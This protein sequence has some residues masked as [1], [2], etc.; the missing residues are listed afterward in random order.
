M[1]PSLYGYSIDDFKEEARELLAR[2]E[3]VLSEIRESPQ[4]RE[5]VNALFRVIHSLK[6][7]AAYT[8]LKDVNTFSHLYEGFLG[9]LRNNKYEV[10]QD[11]INILVRA[12]DYLEDL[13]FQAEDTD[14]GQVDDTFSDPMQQLA[15]VLK[16]RKVS[17]ERGK[18]V[19]LEPPAKAET[20]VKKAPQ[21][22]KKISLT[23]QDPAKMGQKDV[24]K[25]TITNAIKSLYSSLKNAVLDKELT[26]RL[27]TKLEDSVLWA[28]GDSSAIIKPL[29]DMKGL[30]SGPVGPDE[31]SQLRKRFNSLAA[32]LKEEIV[33]LDGPEKG[34]VEVKAEA[35]AE[36]KDE[37]GGKKK[38]PAEAIRGASKDDIVKITLFKSLDTLA[39]LLEKNNPD[40]SQIKR[41]VGRLRDLNRWAFNEDERINRDIKAIEEL[42]RRPYDDVVAQE[43]KTRYTS[44]RPSFIAMLAQ[45]EKEESGKAEIKEDEKIRSSEI[46]NLS[47]PQPL[48]IAT[49]GD[50][51]RNSYSTMRNQKPLPSSGSTLRV[52]SEDVESLIAA[53][54]ELVGLEPK[55]F[56]RLQAHALQLRMVPVGELFSRFRKIVRDLSEELG[57]E[58]DIEISGE[59]VKLDKVIAD[60]LNEPILHML[61]N[62]ASHGLESP[63]EREKLG[64][65]TAGLIRLNAYQEGGQIIIEVSDNGKGISLE[66]VRKRGRE[67]GLI[68]A[69]EKILSE[70]AVLDLIFSP[71][72]STME[73]ADKVSGRGVGMD[74][75]KE[76][77]TSLQGTV[78]IDTKEGIGTTF[79]LQLPLTLAIIKA[80]VLEQSGN[81]L[82]LPSAFVDRVI[83]MTDEELKA[84]SII[85][86]NRL[87]LGLANEGDI[88]PLVN[89]SELFGLESKSRER[90][91]VVIKAGMGQ[92]AALVVDAALGRQPLMVK[93]LDR[94]SENRFF[95]SAS[96]VNDEVIL[97]LNTPSL[98]AATI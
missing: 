92:K 53:I 58:I 32:A 77:I 64:K 22:Q 49:S 39:S 42:L 82:A 73:E 95:S 56:E 68:R 93:P 96:Y 18:N 36:T 50:K 59:S 66:K 27:L 71:G 47:T 94:F 98:M 54:G 14:L 87:S 19:E 16:E 91:V 65:G 67:M 70:K 85:E 89:L 2:A 75:V 5:K 90:C 86:N 11:V 12:R 31:L 26:S 45:K 63:E 6:G 88:L 46:E 62:A 29:D 61:R 40:Y 43:M 24:I 60:R 48:N 30:I 78:S 76:V 34:K 10:S 52:R 44:I 15:M 4:D 37:L 72:F 79:R 17:K 7:S 41:V 9:E 35:E 38:A 13:I 81:K 55:D 80:M 33:S 97:V 21:E 57:K 51:V 3:D 1:E 69:D 23:T 8:G 25:V 84:G 83:T 74:V 20:P 28:F